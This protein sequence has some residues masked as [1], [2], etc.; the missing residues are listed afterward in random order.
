MQQ[1]KKCSLKSSEFVEVTPTAPTQQNTFIP[2]LSLTTTWFLYVNCWA[3]YCRIEKT[4]W[5][6][7]YPTPAPLP[8]SKNQWLCSSPMIY[9]KFS[10]ANQTEAIEQKF[11]KLHIEQLMRKWTETYLLL[12]CIHWPSVVPLICY[13]SCTSCSSR[14][15]CKFLCYSSAL[16]LIST[17]RRP[18]DAQEGHTQALTSNTSIENSD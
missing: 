3:A 17:T 10:T 16:L 2:D 5:L 13:M 9:A 1:N 11:R 12:L 18:H 14:P 4:I 8:Q 7:S 6:P 15:H